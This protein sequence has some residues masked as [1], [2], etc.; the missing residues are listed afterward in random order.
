ME[1]RLNF[2][3]NAGRL[4]LARGLDPEAGLAV[5]H[6][7]GGSHGPNQNAII[8]YQVPDGIPEGSRPVVEIYERI[9]SS[10]FGR[11]AYVVCTPEGTALSAYPVGDGDLET[12]D[13]VEVQARFADPDCVTE[14]GVDHNDLVT[15]R[16]YV[17]SRKGRRGVVQG[18]ILSTCP[19]GAL[20]L[21]QAAMVVV[22]RAA[23]KLAD[24]TTAP[25]F[26]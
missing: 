14:V 7:G 25:T 3:D 5:F 24:P 1:P 26:A 10:K 6:S 19:R 12:P 17:V 23:R 11:V 2:L 4:I 15:I 21:Q 16:Q 22:A 8:Y 13:G 18:Q 9:E 20:N